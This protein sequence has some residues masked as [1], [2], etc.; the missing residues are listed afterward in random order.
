MSFVHL[1]IHT[2]YSFS[3]SI[4]RVNDLVDSVAKLGMPAAAI[5]EFQNMH[6]AVKFYTCCLRRGL[7]PIVGVEALIE[8]TFRPDSPYILVLLCQNLQGYRSLCELSSRTQT[9]SNNSGGMYFKRTDL[10]FSKCEGLIALAGAHRGEVGQL[11]IQK[12]LDEAHSVLE[13]YSNLFPNRF[14]LDITRT[15]QVA[16]QAYELAA[17]NLAESTRTPIVATHSPRFL[18]KEEFGIH[19]I[20]VCVHDRTELSDKN[21]RKDFTEEQYLK[22]PTEMAELF[23]DLPQAIENTLEIAKRCNVRFNLKRTLMPAYLLEDESLK[24]N[25]HLRIQSERG[26]KELLDDQVPEHYTARLN[27]ELEIIRNTDYAGYFLIVA[28]IIN[29]AKS[30]GIEV[31]PGRGSGAGSLVAYALKITTIDPL[32]YDLIFERFLNPDRISPPDFDIDFCVEERDRVIEFVS[33]RYGEKQVA[34]IVT[35][36]TMAARAAVRDVGRVIRRDYLFYDGLAKLI[37]RQ[38]DITLEKALTK[39]DSLKRRY[40]SEER[41]REVFDTAQKLEGTIKNVSKHPGGIVISPSKITDYS[42]LFVD[43]ETGRDVTQF[44]KDD[45][46][47]IGLVK[48]DFLGLTTLTILAR[49]LKSINSKRSE[50]DQ[51]TL[52]GIPLN[53]KKTFQYICTGRTIGIF[54]LESRGMQ[55]L[56]RAMQPSEFNDLVALLALF[57][58]GPLQNNMDQLY[59]NNRKANKYNLLHDDLKEILDSSYGVILYQEQV[60][61]IAQVMSGYSLGEADILRRAIGK[62]LKSEMKLQRERFVNGALNKGYEEA[63]ATQIYDL[64]ES[65][66]GYGFNKSH[67]VAYAL[68]AYQTAYFKTHHL[69]EFLAAFM[70]VDSKI[71]S[72]VKKYRDAL[73]H[74]VQIVPPDINRSGYNFKAVSKNKILYGLGALKKIGKNAVESIQSSREK[75]GLFRDMFDFCMRIDLD[76]VTKS[77][78]QALIDSGAFDRM[79]PNRA[80]LLKQLDSAYG[81]AQQHSQELRSGQANLFSM[82]EISLPAIESTSVSPWSKS[83]QLRREYSI[84]GI[85][86]SGHPFDRYEQELTTLKQSQSISEAKKTRNRTVIVGGWLINLQ[87]VDLRN[88]GSNAYFELRDSSGIL[89]VATYSE[90][91]KL[92]KKTIAE[93]KPL[94]IVGK[95]EEI[96]NGKELRL[97]ANQ[98]LKFENL[99]AL[100]QAQIQLNLYYDRVADIDIGQM[101][102]IINEYLGGDHEIIIEYYSE[103]GASVRFNLLNRWLVTINDEML[104]A[105]KNLL[106]EDS[107]QVDYSKV[108]FDSIQQ[109]T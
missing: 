69:S 30:E 76:R 50:A 6:S 13:H 106:G 10:T 83:E 92:A 53:D 15:G 67:S 91:Y 101:K 77:A 98:V 71:E 14:Y 12:N 23:S 99:R 49:A 5:T 105:L 94:I 51:L 24:I 80:A 47:K 28:D 100:P 64:I 93:N 75:D 68:L 32:E 54:Q 84:L 3:D 74:G 48:F 87:I 9:S 41:T 20:K 26:L 21:R 1:N 16:E 82:N 79:N 86:M 35:Y 88:G 89:S 2:E 107:V 62:K 108:A 95:L 78:C 90:V 18:T 73:D 55:R 96:E 25:D 85:Y 58:P 4:I 36:N 109:L 8:N 34:Q 81:S 11:L 104:E 65:F 19:E 38:L 63:L 59:I 72:I 61:K 31:G 29:W 17:L 37:P 42:A 27:Q 102:A 33:Q 22:T 43:R 40:E 97:V 7:K 45:L 46:E 70:S 44:D 39:V 56:I 60:M 52:E 57:R 66:G 103:Q